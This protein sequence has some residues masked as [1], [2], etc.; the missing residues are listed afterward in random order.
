M[1][2]M[3]I[4]GWLGLIVGVIGGAIGAFSIAVTW[5]LYQAGTK[6]N[7]ETSR[8]LTEIRSSSH[9]TEVTSTRFTEQLIRA[10][11]ELLGRDLKSSL[12]VGRT[13]L[14][15]RIDSLLAQGLS[16]ADPAQAKSIRERVQ[17]AVATAFRTMEFQAARLPELPQPAAAGSRTGTSAAVTAPGMPRLIKWIAKHEPKYAFF[18]VKFLRDRMFARDP[19]VQEALQ[20]AIDEGILETYD[21]PNPKNP[22]WPTK[23]CRLKR[24][25]P[26]VREIL[27]D[28]GETA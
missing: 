13:T 15:E 23:A 14:S 18:S 5:K 3:S 6:V 24:E 12:L 10:L 17:G 25:H 22:A 19:A 2:L 16:G 7:Q 20:L 4:L 27:R 9:T 21:R 28:S 26:L 11:I 8:V 1:D